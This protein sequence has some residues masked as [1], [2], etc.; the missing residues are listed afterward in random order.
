M[1]ETIRDFH[2]ISDLVATSGQPTPEQFSIIFEAGYQ[3]VINLATSSSSNALANEGEIVTDLGMV[4]VHIPVLW[5][6][7][8][9]KD[10]QRFFRVM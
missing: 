10:V 3:I 2:L 9:I 8:Q 5:D 6:K 1:I 4:C 7:P